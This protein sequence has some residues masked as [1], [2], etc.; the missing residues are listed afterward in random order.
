MPQLANPF[1]STADGHSIVERGQINTLEHE[2]KKDFCPEWMEGNGATLQGDG[3]TR[4][5]MDTVELR[6]QYWRRWLVGVL[7]ATGLVVL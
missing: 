6:F 3:V 7:I 5:A 2:K 4:A 1:A